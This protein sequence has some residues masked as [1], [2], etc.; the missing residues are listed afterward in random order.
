MGVFVIKTSLVESDRLTSGTELASVRN[1]HLSSSQSHFFV[2]WFFNKRC[3]YDC[4][5]CP[6]DAHDNVSP[7]LD[8]GLYLKAISRLEKLLKDKSTMW[9]LSGGEVLINPTFTTTLEYLHKSTIRV[10]DLKFLTNL[11]VGFRQLAKVLDIVSD[12]PSCTLGMGAS[13]HWEFAKPQLWIEKLR[14]IRANYPDIKLYPTIMFP[15]DSNGWKV[16]KE[17]YEEVSEFTYADAR[18]L[19]INLGEE[20]YNYSKDQV[21]WFDNYYNKQ[22]ANRPLTTEVHSVDGE[23]YRLRAEAELN[24][25][26]LNQFKN[27]KCFAGYR[28]IYINQNLEVFRSTCGKRFN[29]H[30]MGDLIND[31]VQLYNSPSYCEKDY[32]LCT[33]DLGLPKWNPKSGE[34][35]WF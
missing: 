4:S 12:Y 24:Y 10:R 7:F 11:S 25:K 2:H 16:S 5:Y 13:F 28:K 17:V 14:W 31:D 22:K 9:E 23:T 35:K 6:A 15:V 29:P 27:W 26:K 1:V 21:A 3:N 19:R 18:P 34:P 30:K 8:K 20:L 32:C 33:R